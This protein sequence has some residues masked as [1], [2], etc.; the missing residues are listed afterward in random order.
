M[1][2]PP[3]DAGRSLD[4]EVAEKV[5]GLVPCTA[6]H[7]GERR[8]IYCHARPTSPSKGGETP[9]YS[10]DIGAAMTVVVEV[11]RR[12]PGWRFGLLGGD[13]T[14]GY[15]GG[16]PRKGVDESSRVAFGWHAEFFG[17]IDPRQCYGDRHG[18]GRGETAA[19]A[20]CL[21]SLAALSTGEGRP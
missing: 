13:V 1:T 3:R 14:M 17:H 12:N 21:A 18:E 9:A 20:I 2:A 10:T 6:P 11:Q 19:H 15:F 16:S 5:M 4:A 7:K 8:P